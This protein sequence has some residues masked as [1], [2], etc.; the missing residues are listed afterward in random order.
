[1]K[2]KSN[3]WIASVI[4]AN[5]V[6][7]DLLLTIP[8]VVV[9][10]FFALPTF[11]WVATSVLTI[12]L[13]VFV[14]SWY[15]ARYLKSRVR[16]RSE[17]VHTIAIAAP[18]LLAILYYAFAVL[19]LLMSLFAPEPSIAGEPSILVGLAQDL[20][21]LLIYSVV[22]YFVVHKD[23]HKVADFQILY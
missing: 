4:A 22:I 2:E 13:A 11:V 12:F 3:Y 9:W 8:F 7:F 18:L 10:Y 21:S 6:A 14:G 16:V 5:I 20:I 19:G 1:M 15:A 17:H 23:L